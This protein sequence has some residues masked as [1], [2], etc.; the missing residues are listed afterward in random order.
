MSLV[1]NECENKIKMQT[2]WL[3]TTYIHHVPSSDQPP[4][5]I[6]QI[7]IAVKII[8]VTWVVYNN[9]R[10]NHQVN[11]TTQPANKSRVKNE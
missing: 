11:Y 8:Q 6:N 3:A 2:P 9:M 10:T 5:P 1:N 4:R 7:K